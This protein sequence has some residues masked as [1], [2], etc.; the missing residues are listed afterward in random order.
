MR[1]IAETPQLLEPAKGF[2]VRQAVDN[3]AWADMGDHVIVVDALEQPVL[4]GEVMEAIRS[5]TAGKPVR[6]VLNTH[7]HHDHTALN[8]AFQRLFGADIVNAATRRIPADGRWFEGPLRRILMLPT[9]GCHTEG[10]CVVWSPA[11]GVLCVGDIF[12]WGLI[13]LS[14]PLDDD[15][16]RTLETTVERLIDLGAATVVPGHGPLCTTAELRRWLDYFRWLRRE[17]VRASTAGGSDATIRTALSPPEDMRAWWRFLQW[18]HE[19]SLD[20][21]LAAV[22]NGCLH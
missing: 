17:V 10:D 5:T 20:K 1:D 19:D 6:W 13:P 21:V 12:G 18:K 22:R 14:G 15:S 9:P 7:T 4:E 11:D 8:D 2:F 3:M 16:A